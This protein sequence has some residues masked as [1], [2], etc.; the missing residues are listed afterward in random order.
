MDYK[1][2]LVLEILYEYIGDKSQFMRSCA[3]PEDVLFELL[4]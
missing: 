1:I 4:L 3:K 2:E